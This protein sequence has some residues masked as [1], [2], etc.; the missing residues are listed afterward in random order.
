MLV[1]TGSAPL[2]LI[3]TSFLFHFL[4]FQL[5]QAYGMI[6]FIESVLLAPKTYS[7]GEKHTDEHSLFL[8]N[9]FKPKIHMVSRSSFF[10]I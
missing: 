9:I 7:E 3:F 4:F 5:E 2:C 1:L 6:T 10:Q 8:V